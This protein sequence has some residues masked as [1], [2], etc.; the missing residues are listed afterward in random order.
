M[1]EH[2]GSFGRRPRRLLDGVVGRQF[3]DLGSRQLL[4]DLRDDACP[5]PPPDAG[6]TTITTPSPSGRG[7]VSTRSGSALGMAE[8][9]DRRHQ[10]TPS[11]A[12][13]APIAEADEHV[14]GV[15]RA[16]RDAGQPDEPGQQRQHQPQQQSS[17]APHQPRTPRRSP[18]GRREA[19]FDVGRRRVCRE[20]GTKR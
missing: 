15:V 9:D 13:D 17:P 3:D 11:T 16:G 20:I 6:L 8:V 5:T 14:A 12:I 10:P 18:N 19:E 4:A 7:G 2:L 1:A